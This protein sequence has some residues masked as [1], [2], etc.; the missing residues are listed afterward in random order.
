MAKYIY[1]YK[2]WT[3]FTW[4]DKAINTI[5]EEVKL[6]H[7]KII[8]QMNALDFSAKEKSALTVLTLDIVKSSEMEGELLDYYQ[9]RSPFARR[10]GIIASRFCT[11]A[12]VTSKVL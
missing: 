1:G 12:A 5:F 3:D 6:M 4:D 8:G 10:L 11:Q 2:N 9:V 7:G